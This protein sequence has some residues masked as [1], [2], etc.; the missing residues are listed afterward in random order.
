M[1]SRSP[2]VQAGN[3]WRKGWPLVAA[4]M[5]GIGTG[6]G[7]FQ[8]VS[9][10]FTA[11]MTA[12]FG[13]TRGEIATAAGLGLAGALAA[14]FIGRLADR[15]G[16][17]AVI[18]AAMLLL[19]LAYCGMSLLTGLLWHYQLLVVCLAL[20]VPG[21][22]A[23]VHG[24][25]ISS[26]FVSHRGLALGIATSGLSVTTIVVPPLLALVIAVSGWRGGF[27]ALAGLTVLLALPLVLLLIRGASS[28]PAGL[29][30][31]ASG[32]ALL[33]GATGAQAR[34][35]RSFWLLASSVMLINMATIGLV[36]QL[37]PFGLDRGLSAAQAAL[38]LASYGA[39]QVVGRLAMGALVDRFSPASMAACAA[40]LSAIG[41][42]LLQLPMPGFALLMLAVFVAGL[43]NGAEHDL[44]PFFAARLFGL[45]AYGEIYGT[46][47]MLALAGTATGIVAFGRLHDATGGYG[48]ALAI[49]LAAMLLA[50][51]AFL[52]LGK[53]RPYAS[54]EPAPGTPSA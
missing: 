7:L 36:T 54:R 6:P 53:A 33:S 25:L 2:T 9:S 31:D 48:V 3:E 22:S 12:E 13:W 11:G 23:L 14:P 50:T 19:G 46:L 35:S 1:E 47:L 38:L 15:I 52:G 4:G 41:F 49:G 30:V 20:S 24:K 17:R 10:L 45:R 34:R 51:L 39:S 16:V 27:L 21:T 18:V 26:V 32:A 5:I 43:M 37:V 28:S 40:I 42:G 29:A 8:N 44:L